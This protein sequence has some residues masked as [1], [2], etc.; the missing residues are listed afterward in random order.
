[1]IATFLAGIVFYGQLFY[2]PQYFQVVREASAI[3]SGVLLL[4]LV[5]VQTTA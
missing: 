2:L 5:L 4:P 1:M 3:R